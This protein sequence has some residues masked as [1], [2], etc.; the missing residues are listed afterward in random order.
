[1]RLISDKAVIG[2]KNPFLKV[3]K[4]KYPDVRIDFNDKRVYGRRYKT[5]NSFLSEE[6]MKEMESY[7]IQSGFNTKIYRW[8]GWYVVIEQYN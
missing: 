4:H 5:M 2:A 7:M 1:M 3:L 8:D 6:E